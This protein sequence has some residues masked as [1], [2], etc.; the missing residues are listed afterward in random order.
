MS[1]AGVQ[2]FSISLDGFGVGEGQSPDAHFNRNTFHFIDASPADALKTAREAA[3]VQDVRI[4]GGPSLIR[5]FLAAGLV[6][7]LHLVVIP[8]LLGG[9][10]RLWAG[11]EGLELTQQTKGPCV[12]AHG[13]S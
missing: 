6:D 3:A 10:V 11:L 12:F 13:D 4:G 5:D 2:N 1:L 8:I 7:H 9:G